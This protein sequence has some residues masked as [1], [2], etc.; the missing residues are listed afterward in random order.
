MGNYAEKISLCA[1]SKIFGFEPK[2]GLAMIARIGSAAEIFRL[3]TKDID[4]ML[5]PHSKYRGAICSKALDDAEAMLESLSKSGARFTGW[6]EDGYPQLLK[7]CPDAPIGLYAK[8]S[9][10]DQELWSGRMPIAVVGTRD[11]SPYGREWCERIVHALA[12]TSAKPLI[13]SG[14][15]IGTDICAHKAA[16][17]A[18]LP[19]IAVMATGTDT[20]YPYRHRQI[21]E[22]MSCTQ[23]CALVTDYPPGTAPLPV[24][25]LRRNRI[26]AGL[27]HATILVESKIKGGGMMTCRL[28]FSYDRDVYALPGRADDLRS[29]GCNHLIRARMAEPLTSEEDLIE[30]LGL[31]A[32]GRKSPPS[33]MELLF[34]EYG[35]KESDETICRMAEILSAIRGSR[36]ITVEELG[37]DIGLPYGRTVHLAGLLETDGFISCDLLRRCSLVSARF[38]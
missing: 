22:K 27:S 11:I 30:S 10:Q 23:G 16:L 33:D 21:A 29:Q 15:A 31:F 3:G 32:T 5:G 4:G 38:R 14:L 28:A 13:V 18:G 12:R 24:N 6:T 37:R 17:E 20:I 25:F 7:E 2:I 19:T 36:G 35:G 9:T 26:I 8:S 34:E 1:M